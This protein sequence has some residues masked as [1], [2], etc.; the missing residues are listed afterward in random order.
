MPSVKLICLCRKKVKFTI[1]S[2]GFIAN[3]DEEGKPIVGPRNFTTR[4]VLKGKT[5]KVLLA[6][7]VSY[8]S[9]GDPFKEMSL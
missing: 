6:K 4:P 7:A 8:T 5:D 3:K 9:I 2:N 1:C